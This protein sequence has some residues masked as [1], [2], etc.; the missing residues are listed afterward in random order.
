MDREG[1][2]YRPQASASDLDPINNR[3]FDKLDD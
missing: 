3:S 2:G 1:N